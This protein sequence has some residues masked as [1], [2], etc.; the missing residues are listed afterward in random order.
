MCVCVSVSVCV[1]VFVSFL[2]FPTFE[3]IQV[4]QF[5]FANRQ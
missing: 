3:P 5:S 4:I 2:Y 1:C